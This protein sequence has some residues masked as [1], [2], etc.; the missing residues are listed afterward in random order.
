MS[1]DEIRHLLNAQLDAELSTSESQQLEA[2]LRSDATARQ[3]QEAL[4]RLDEAL[5][6]QLAPFAGD[7]TVTRDVLARLPRR[8]RVP[9]PVGARGWGLALAGVAAGFLVAMLILPAVTSERRHQ[10]AERG[11]GVEFMTRLD[12]QAATAS[13]GV[14]WVPGSQTEKRPLDLATAVSGRGTLH[15]ASGGAAFT[16]SGHTRMRL[17]AGSL[18]AVQTSRKLRMLEGDGW[19]TVSSGWTPATRDAW[20][21]ELP[22]G[23][24]SCEAGDFIIHVGPRLTQ[25]MVISG[26]VRYQLKNKSQTLYSG[27]GLVVTTADGPR[28]PHSVYLLPKYLGWSFA[29]LASPGAD[30]A[31]RQW[32]VRELL[33]NLE[34]P[35]ISSYCEDALV[36]FFATQALPLA[37]EQLQKNPKMKPSGRRHLAS[38]VARVAHGQVGRARVETLFDLV[39][40]NDPAIRALLVK[41]LEGATLMAA[42]LPDEIVNGEPQVRR[43]L[44]NKWRGVWEQQRPAPTED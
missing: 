21:I 9:L 20:T 7:G 31:D 37:A 26:T 28:P 39:L 30:A 15:V 32:L 3:E 33:R 12:A 23:D 25:I 11:V 43:D 40:D 19:W 29:L 24:L 10:N 38:L 36:E 6:A 34:N 5:R 2:R 18:V 4:E 27:D 44:V 8:R 14:F 41:A 13:G 17:G 1:I 16:L 35:E 22:I 42:P